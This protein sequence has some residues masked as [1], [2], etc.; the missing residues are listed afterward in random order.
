MAALIG[1]QLSPSSAALCRVARRWLG[2]WVVVLGV[3][4]SPSA[5]LSV[6]TRSPGLRVSANRH[7]LERNDGSPFFYLGDTAWMLCQRLTREDVDRYLEDRASKGF[8]VIQMVALFSLDANAYGQAPLVSGDP[9]RPNDAYFQHVDYVVK[10][11]ASLGLY[12]GMLPTWGHLWKQTEGRAIFSK[13]KA[14]SFGRFLGK[15]YGE[16]PIIWILGGDDNPTLPVERQIIDAM[17]AGL[18]QGDGGT[19][20]RT[21]H[22]RGPGRSSE[23][24]HRAAWLDFNMSQSSHGARDHDNGL[25]SEA[26][27][28]L[29]PEKPTVDGE[30]RYE[31]I[32][33]GF[34]WSNVDRSARF[35][36]YDVRQAAYWSLLAGACGH[37]YGNNNVWQ[38]HT[39]ERLGEIAGNQPWREALDHP[40]ALQMRFVRRLFESRPFNKLE[41]RQ[42]M[43]LDGPAQ[44]GAKIR[45]ARATD[46]AFAFVYSPRGAPFTIDQS[47]IKGS[48]LKKLWYDPRYGVAYWLHTGST[49][50]IQTYTPPTEGRG[51]DWILIIEDEAEGFPALGATAPPR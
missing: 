39:G 35:D 9:E 25:F 41:P 34:Y 20:L 18:S 27:F 40:G 11:A 44:G 37:T 3:W 28:R 7:Y 15:R 8:T 49:K 32:P 38:F 23:L 48:R 2:F 6:E 45:A 16:Q 12:V 33:I 5:A 13:D 29:K 46:G 1:L 26:D 10:K 51:C 22:P 30:P 17:A 36:D 21:Y 50:A 42:S 24:V 43:I 14:F 47:V 4:W 19:H 31:A